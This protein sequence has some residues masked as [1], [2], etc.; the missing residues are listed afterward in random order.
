MKSELKI[1]QYEVKIIVSIRSLMITGK[2]ITIFCMFKV[3]NFKK[4]NVLKIYKNFICCLKN[5]YTNRIY[6]MHNC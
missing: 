1:E 5:Y 4:K 3:L 6:I 2:C